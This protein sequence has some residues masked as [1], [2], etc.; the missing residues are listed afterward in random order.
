MCWTSER[1]ELQITLKLAHLTLEQ[2]T[3]LVGLITVT[4]ATVHTSQPVCSAAM[5]HKA[6]MLRIY[7]E[8]L[9]TQ[10]RYLKRSIHWHH[11]VVN[12]VPQ[13][14]YHL[15]SLPIAIY[16][17]RTCS[18][19]FL[20]Q[21]LHYIFFTKCL[22]FTC[23]LWIGPWPFAAGD[24]STVCLLQSESTTT[25]TTFTFRTIRKPIHRK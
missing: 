12:E 15:V 25:T 13:L 16:G 8:W 4:Q 18:Q 9:M 14:V 17:T 11:S 22:H 1:R 10:V 21:V 23:V 6:E 20:H 24:P 19:L 3:R 7:T 5:V 2:H